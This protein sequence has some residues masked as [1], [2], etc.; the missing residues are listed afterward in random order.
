MSEKVPVNNDTRKHRAW[1]AAV[2]IMFTVAVSVAGACTAHYQTHPTSERCL[3]G[4]EHVK[5]KDGWACAPGA[6][7]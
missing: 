5:V 3:P 7:Q 6:G 2:S 1:A 4:T